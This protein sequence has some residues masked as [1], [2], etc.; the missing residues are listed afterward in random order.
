MKRDSN[1]YEFRSPAEI[2]R[3]VYQARGAQTDPAPENASGAAGNRSCGCHFGLRET[4]YRVASRRWIS[5]YPR[6]V[7]VRT[8][9][10]SR[11]VCSRIL[12]AIGQDR[13]ANLYYCDEPLVSRQDRLI[14]FYDAR[15][16]M[17]TTESLLSFCKPFSVVLYRLCLWI[18]QAALCA[19]RNILHTRKT[20]C[21]LLVWYIRIEL[22]LWR[23]LG[24]NASDEMLL[25]EAYQITHT[26]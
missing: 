16:T 19:C 18:A 10:T 3:L 5:I 17:P 12:K 9:R 25:K 21:C 15:C 23:L 26:A 2:S 20:P 7:Q 13:L 8:S 4:S 11:I 6:N 24:L 22:R 14:H 1:R